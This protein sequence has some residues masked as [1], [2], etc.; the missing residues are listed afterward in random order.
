MRRLLNRKCALVQARCAF[1]VENINQPPGVFSQIPLQFA[2]FIE[3][4]LCRWIHHPCALTLV[5]IVDFD[6]ARGEI[7]R[8]RLGVEV[9]LAKSVLAI[10]CVTLNIYEFSTPADKQVLV[11]AMSRSPGRL[12]MTVPIIGAHLGARTKRLGLDRL[13]FISC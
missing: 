4:E 11:Q 13:I 5:L 10:G 3:D 2:L 7:K 1:P 6:D 12:V 9:G 8:L